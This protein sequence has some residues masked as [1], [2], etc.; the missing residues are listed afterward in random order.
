MEAEDHYNCNPMINNQA[1][2]EV[3][4][5]RKAAHCAEKAL[6][7]LNLALNILVYSAPYFLRR[8]GAPKI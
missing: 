7:P 4:I 5:T 1:L 8:A 6:R 2:F 3:I